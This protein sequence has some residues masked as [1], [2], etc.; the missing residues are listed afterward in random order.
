[1]VSPLCLFVRAAVACKPKVVYVTD[2]HEP[3]L[4]NSAFN[5]ELNAGTPA[6]FFSSWTLCVCDAHCC[7][8]DNP[9][10]VALDEELGE[11]YYQSSLITHSASSCTALK[12]LKMNWVDEASF[13]PEKVDLL[14]G[15][16]LVYDASILA[17]LIPA[18]CAVLSAG[19]CVLL[20][21]VVLTN[22]FCAS[23]MLH[24]CLLLCEMHNFLV[25]LLTYPDAIFRR[26]LFVLRPR[27]WAS[28][29]AGPRDG[30]GPGG[31]RR[32]GEVRRT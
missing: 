1:M 14:L 9:T 22:A 5:V 10:A 4:L 31:H 18:I 6:P 23:L 32:S 12:V 16:D 29:H 25:H 8:V 3:T 2:I 21:G 19:E 11:N 13:P 26:I 27:H 30:A 20:L 7:S 28:R 15:S 17:V 24:V